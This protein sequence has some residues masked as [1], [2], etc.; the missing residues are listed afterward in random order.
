MRRRL[1]RIA[2]A[3]FAVWAALALVWLV[4]TAMD[5]RA[6]RDAA[7]AARDQLGADQVADG[8]PLPELRTAAARLGDAHDR[9]GGLLL[10]P[11]RVLP[12]VGRQLRSVDALA[13]AAAE[14]ARAGVDAVEE[15]Q[16]VFADPAGE[17]TARVEQVRLIAELVDDVATRLESID[18]LG[19]REGLLGPLAEARNDLAADLA[20]ARSSLADARTGSRAALSLVEGP[21]RYLVIAANN[22]EM[23]AGSGMWL[24]G[25]ALTTVDGR[26]ELEPMRS[27]HVDADPPTGAVAPTGVLA[28][29][30]GF[31][32]PGDEW[33]NLMSSPTFPVSAELGARMWEAAGNGR[34][35]GVLVVDAIG[36]Q[37]IVAATGPVTVDGVSLTAEDIPQQVLHDQ[38]LRYEDLANQ[39]GQDNAERRESL[40]AIAGA[41]VAAIDK[42]DYPAST[43]IRELGEAIEGRH[44]LAW[45]R[46]ELEQAGWEAAG[47]SGELP[48]DGLL[49]S[50]QN[51]GTNKLDWFLDVEADLSLERA[52]EAWEVTVEV[53]L[54]N[55]TPESEPR[56]VQGPGGAPGLPA[57][58]YR[59]LVML[60]APSAARSLRVEMVE[61]IAVTGEDGPTKV[62]GYSVDVARRETATVTFRFE[63]PFS[64]RHLEVLASAR[65]PTVTWRHGPSTR[66][67]SASWT[68]KW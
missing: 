36:L 52:D 13:G 8:E 21:R 68:A 60:N 43:L 62:I 17:G 9:A 32:A 67:D 33:R 49:L 4:R 35:D 7:T 6:G 54:R 63:L 2:I 14:I 28:D 5:L 41:A 23:R 22:A 51:R 19:P 66:E 29:M 25:G 34:V 57:G 10:A 50:I 1:L 24:S 31:L 61:R 11:L 46:D 53:Q 47:M 55:E 59:G 30:W 15:A 64:S 27:L 38:Y 58:A 20:D 26:L 45:S 65:V 56:Y 42:G 16:R 37:A 12:V 39:F 18:D 48:E 40:A 3:A 44:V